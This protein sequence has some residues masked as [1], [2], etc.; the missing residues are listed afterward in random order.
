MKGALTRNKQAIRIQPLRKFLCQ[1]D[2]E[3]GGETLGKANP[4][5]LT[6]VE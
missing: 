2:M 1:G 5:H 4:G 3:N 6:A